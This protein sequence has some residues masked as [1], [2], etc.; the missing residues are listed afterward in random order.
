MSN[1]ILLVEDEPSDVLFLKLALQKNGLHNTLNVAKDGKEAQKYLKGEGKFADREQYPLPS[2]V[3]LDLRL[4][5]IPGLEVLKWIREHPQ[6]EMLPVIVFTSSN[7]HS[8]VETAYRLGAN[9]YLVKPAN[10]GELFE[11]VRRFKLY[12]LELN[13][14]PPPPLRSSEGVVRKSPERQSN[15][16]SR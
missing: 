2:L 3:L 13:F 1:F 4:P 7:Q 15:R 14:P 6:F 8:D 11:L 16:E 5:Q 9:S 10:P 12:W